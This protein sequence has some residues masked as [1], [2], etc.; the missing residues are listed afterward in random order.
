MRRTL[1]LAVLL[2]LGACGVPGLTAEDVLVQRSCPERCP[3]TQVC[4]AEGACVEPATLTGTVEDACTGAALA[5]RVTI[6]GSSVCSGDMKLPYFE[7]TGLAPGGP[8][9]LA[10]GKVGYRSY[11]VARSLAP[12]AN[13][14]PAI[15]LTPS[16]GCGAPPAPM[17]CTCTD[18][19]CQR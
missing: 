19:L 11:S 6:A 13:T 16:N 4:G 15:A 7:L 1:H 14:H 3:A 12:G 5:A 2:S 8:Y 18:A 17:A 9:T 10:V